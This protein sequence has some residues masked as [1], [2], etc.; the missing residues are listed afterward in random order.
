MGRNYHTGRTRIDEFLEE[1]NVPEMGL[2]RESEW[3][4]VMSGERVVFNVI[5]VRSVVHDERARINEFVGERNVLEMFF[6]E[7]EGEEG[8]SI[9]R[10]E[11]AVFNVM[12]VKG[13]C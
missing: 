12:C 9:I 8:K 7:S 6:Q 1:R 2:L 3:C 5:C 13:K 11:C 10:G 4:S